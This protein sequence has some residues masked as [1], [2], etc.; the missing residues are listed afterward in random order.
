MSI[1]KYYVKLN[2]INNYDIR[3]LHLSCVKSTSSYIEKVLFDRSIGLQASCMIV[4][5]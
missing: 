5:G 4:M 1:E 3:D 2:W